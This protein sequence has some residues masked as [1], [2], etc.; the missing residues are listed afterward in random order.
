MSEAVT[1]APP[2]GGVEASRI[3][4]VHD[5][6]Q[7]GPTLMVLSGIHGNEPAGVHAC[8]RVLARL[9]EAQPEFRGRFVALAG[10]IQALHQGQRFLRR[11]LNRQWSRANVEV[12][13]ALPEEDRS[14]EDREQLELISEFERLAASATGPIICLD[15]HTSSAEGAPFSCLADTLPNRRLAMALPV[16]VILG[17]EECI[18]GAV[19]E[20]FDE[21]GQVGLA[22]E[23]G[24]HDEPETIDN[25][26]A[27]VWL[28]LR[29]AGLMA[30]TAEDRRRHEAT[31]RR[32]S[33]NLPPVLEIRYRHAISPQ[34]EFVMKPGYES[35]DPVAKGESLGN[36][37]NGPVV[38]KYPCRVLLPLYQGQGDDGFFLSR[39]VRK[40][41][42]GVSRICRR[43][44]LWN[45]AH[46]LPGVRKDPHDPLSVLVD[47]HVARWLV[48]QIFH[49]LGFRKKRPAASGCGSRG[50]G[51]YL[52]TTG[53]VHTDPACRRAAV[54]ALRLPRDPVVAG[55]KTTRSV[56]VMKNSFSAA[57]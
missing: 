52:R 48:V 38:A 22:L 19:M 17:L 25:L 1:T 54:S 34:D 45:L 33:P 7:P 11:D 46:W 26:E 50:V 4:G 28:T 21:R 16:P 20:Y 2:S 5:S 36:D 39:P 8:R 9:A 32:A 30:M 56:S 12:V 15:L 47:P 40:A 27:G 29:A 3:L 13:R 24:Q 31:L 23:G 35:F 44:R 43:L 6:G 51:R 53:S 10:N 41:W 49:L 55:Q 18:D 14:S 42:L 57:S 37:R